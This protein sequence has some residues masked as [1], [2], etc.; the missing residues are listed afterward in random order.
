M[1]S[2]IKP[3]NFRVSLT[4]VVGI[5]LLLAAACGSDEAPNVGGAPSSTPAGETIV[6]EAE[7]AVDNDGVLVRYAMSSGECPEC[8]FEMTLNRDGTATLESPLGN[9]AARFEPAMLTSFVADFDRDDLIIGR[10][11]CGRERDGN[12]P[13]MSLPGV[14]LDLCDYE[15]DEQHPL[16]IQVESELRRLQSLRDDS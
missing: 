1:R 10:D 3:I 9:I 15:I 6:E 11:D 13:V 12:A 16:I 2:T 14:E 5:S 4:V 8:G 7:P